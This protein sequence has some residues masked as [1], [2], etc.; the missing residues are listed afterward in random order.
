LK[1][2]LSGTNIETNT[3]LRVVRFNHNGIDFVNFRALEF[4]WRKIKIATKALN[5]QPACRHIEYFTQ[6]IQH[7]SVSIKLRD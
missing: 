2:G 1:P 6:A 7:G 5:H 3:I 4:W